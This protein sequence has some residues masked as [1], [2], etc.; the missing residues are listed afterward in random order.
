MFTGFTEMAWTFPEEINITEESTSFSI[1]GHVAG[2][3]WSV[4]PGSCENTYK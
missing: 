4:M 2:P 1:R 3:G